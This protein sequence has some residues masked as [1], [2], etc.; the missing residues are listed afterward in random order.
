MNPNIKHTHEIID[1]AI[2]LMGNTKAGKTTL[3]HAM[4]NS[5]LVGERNDLGIVVYKVMQK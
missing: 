2:I 4:E 5:V 3:V 1:K